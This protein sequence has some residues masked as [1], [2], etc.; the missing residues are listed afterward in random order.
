MAGYGTDDGFATWLVDNGYALPDGAPE[1]A[2][3]R[4]RG[5]AYLDGLYGPQFWGAPTSGFAQERA[6]PRTGAMAYG[7]AVSPDVIPDAIV[8]A[9][10][11]AALHE[12]ASPGSLAPTATRAGQVKR[13]KVDVVEV[14]YFAG[15]GDVIADATP[16]FGLIEGLLDP[17]I[18]PN[19]TST[20]IG[21][22]AIGGHR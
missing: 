9:S 14:E 5:S 21:V 10:Y 4:Q 6:W 8:Q 19:I 22:F 18:Q 11:F 1:P 12:A 13:E 7:S 15:S 20:P 17:F 16:R 2:I 3:L